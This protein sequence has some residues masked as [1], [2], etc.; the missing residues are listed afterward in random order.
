[1]T[2]IPKIQPLTP[3]LK[4]VWS[5]FG[6]DGIV[7]YVLREMNISID[8]SLVIDVGAWDGYYLS[9]CAHLIEQG[10]FGLLIEADKNRAKKAQHNFKDN[11]KVDVLNKFM[12]EDTDAALIV[13]DKKF[14]QV[15]LLSIDIDGN[16][17]Q[18]FRNL[19]E[20]L[21]VVVVIEFNPTIPLHIYF[22]NPPH[23]RVGSSAK[24]I[25]DF[26]TSRGYKLIHATETNLIFLNTIS[27]S[28]SSIN[29][30]PLNDA[31]DD[32]NTVRGLWVGYDGS[33]FVDGPKNLE[34]PWHGLTKSFRSLN[35]HP[36]LIGF[37][38]EYSRFQEIAYRYFWFRQYW[39]KALHRRFIK[40]VGKIHI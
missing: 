29:N 1:M 37:R 31:L 19:I 20:L 36:M 16:D 13:R 6:E 35:F 10:A 30:L 25:Y 38:D 32:T 27:D 9:N 4:N 2:I 33:V 22:E 21:P 40:L 26:A 5:Q 24:A 34:F 28:N 23:S 12:E 15:S 8:N 3:H 14:E 17:L 7:S 11:P 18:V 39:K